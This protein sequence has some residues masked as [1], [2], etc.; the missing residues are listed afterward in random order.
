MK[1]DS[2]FSIQVDRLGKRYR[3]G[4]IGRQS[5]AEEFQHT[6]KRV[7]MPNVK[8]PARSAVAANPLQVG[9]R[10]ATQLDPDHPGTFWSLKNVSFR[11]QPGELVAVIGANGAGKSTLL[12]ILARITSPTEGHAR[13]RGRLSSL[14]EVG[15][16]FHPE[17][18]GR[19]NVYVNGA[20]L[21]MQEKEINQKFD[22]IVAFSEVGEFIDTPVKRY[23]SGMRTRLAFSVAAH[24]EPDV[25]LLD[26]VLSVGD[27]S[28]QQKCSDKMNEL[29]G[30]GRTVLIVSHRFSTITTMCPRSLWIHQGRLKKDGPTQEV[31]AAYLSETTGAEGEKIWKNGFTPGRVPGLTLFAFRLLNHKRDVIKVMSEDQSLHVEFDA[32]WLAGTP[33]SQLGIEVTKDQADSLFE[34]FPGPTFSF[35]SP[36]RKRIFVRTP[37]GCLP[38][39]GYLVYALARVERN[40]RSIR[41]SKALRLEVIAVSGRPPTRGKLHVNATWNLHPQESGS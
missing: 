15:T 13:I 22:E 31:L 34:S 12:K 3:L 4:V 23:S 5:L 39:G 32:E 28:F 35:P 24:L 21:G 14:L 40:A 11:L 17:L 8:D 18:T 6:M 19:E 2:N 30:H 1:N 27:A 41:I 37:E 26:E 36:G 7:L 25:L 38:P 9:N 20:I 16:G 29:A 10:L 33:N